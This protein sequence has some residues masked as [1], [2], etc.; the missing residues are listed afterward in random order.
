MKAPDCTGLPA[1]E[2]A[3]RLKAAGFSIRVVR[4]EG[5]R[6]LAGA[7]GFCVVRQ[8]Q[9]NEPGEGPLVELTVC[10]FKRGF[11]L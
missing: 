5:Y 10:N 7:D 4:C 9:T 6:A 11:Q 1:N 3:A 8:R 2:A